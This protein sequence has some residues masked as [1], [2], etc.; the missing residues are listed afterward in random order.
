MQLW[1]LDGGPSAFGLY[2][3]CPYGQLGVHLPSVYMCIVLCVKLMW[4]NGFAEIYVRSAM[5]CAKH[6]VAVLE[7]SMLN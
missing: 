5:R 1:L 2:V 4:C 7:A 6:S 3:Y